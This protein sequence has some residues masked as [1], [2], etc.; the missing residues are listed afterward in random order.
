MIIGNARIADE[1]DAFIANITESTNDVGNNLYIRSTSLKCAG[2][3]ISAFT[4]FKC[5]CNTLCNCSNLS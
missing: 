5:F 4:C 1:Y 2:E 3:C